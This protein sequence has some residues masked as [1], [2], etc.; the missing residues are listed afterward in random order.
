SR[1][2]RRRASRRRRS[3]T[4]CRRCRRAWRRASRAPPAKRDASRP[5]A[6]P[7]RGGGPREAAM[8][9]ATRVV[10]LEGR[11]LI[12][13]HLDEVLW[14]EDLVTKDERLDYYNNFANTQLPLLPNHPIRLQRSRDPVT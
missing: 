9:T 14:P 4:S 7:P 2:R 11:R 6:A 5:A 1:R 10:D 12:L 3:W 8:T 13:T